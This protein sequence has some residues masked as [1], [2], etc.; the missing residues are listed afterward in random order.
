MG[1]T[2]G[3][4]FADGCCECAGKGD[5]ACPM[6]GL[7]VQR[8]G[9]CKADRDGEFVGLV[10]EADL[11]VDERRQL[12]RQRRQIRDFGDLEMEEEYDEEELYDD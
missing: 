9:E 5:P 10:E 2:S 1:A 12:A 11:S 7:D 6:Y 4:Y 3:R 8:C